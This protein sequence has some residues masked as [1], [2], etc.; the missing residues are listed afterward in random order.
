VIDEIV[1]QT[2]NHAIEFLPLDLG[3]LASVSACADAFL[4][5]DEPLHGL[6]NNAGIAGTRG[7]TQ[8][9]YEL[10]FGTNH[11]GPFLLTNRLLD[12]LRESA[13][14]RIVNVS[15]KAHYRVRGIDFEAVRMPTKSRT[16][17]P[18]YGASKLANL[19]HVQ[20]LARRLDGTGVTTYA[21]HPGV[22]ASDIWRSVPWPVRPMIKRAMKTPQQG[23]QTSLHCATSPALAGESGHYYDDCQRVEPGAAATPELAAELW[24]R[25]TAWVE[26]LVA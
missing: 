26:S 10:A 16:A 7:T 25:S 14:A 6:I 20:E 9:G 5:R 21:L 17:L 11:V 3:D 13:P 8:S 1:T 4:E 12:R 19:L 23:A 15:S 2:G 18:E 22:I 24:E